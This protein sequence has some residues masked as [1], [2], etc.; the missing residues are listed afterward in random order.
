MLQTLTEHL[1]FYSAKMKN[2]LPFSSPFFMVLEKVSDGLGHLATQQ[3]RVRDVGRPG[4]ERFHYF[5]PG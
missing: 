4:F 5:G 3:H 1:A 2:G